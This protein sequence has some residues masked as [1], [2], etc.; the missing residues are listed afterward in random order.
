MLYLLVASFPWATVD[1]LLF[2][3]RH[4]NTAVTGDI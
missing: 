3:S 2:N 1:I 4:L